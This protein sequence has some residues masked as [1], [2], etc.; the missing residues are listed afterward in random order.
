MP[1]FLVLSNFTWFLN[2]SQN[3]FDSAV[4]D[5]LRPSR[6]KINQFNALINTVNTAMEI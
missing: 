1:K 2:F 6:W 5:F 4:D 3:I